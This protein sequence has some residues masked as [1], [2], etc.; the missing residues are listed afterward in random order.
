MDK[1]T[2]PVRAVTLLLIIICLLT[3]QARCRSMDDGGEK[4]NLPY[5]LCVYDKRSFAC[6]GER[7]YCCR[8]AVEVCYLSMKECMTECVKTMG[9]P[10]AAGAGGG[11]ASPIA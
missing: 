4:I 6:K 5:G 2:A 10:P 11:N 1:H 8:V 3:T 7:C 9:P